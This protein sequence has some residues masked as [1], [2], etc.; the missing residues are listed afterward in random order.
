MVTSTV[1]K[2]G[3]G[4]V[5]VKTSAPVKKAEIFLVL[6]RLSDIEVAAPVEIGDIIVKDVLEGIHI[7]ATQRVV[8]GT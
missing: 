4:T 5:S 7:V 8:T 2:K 1:Q 6:S 3:D